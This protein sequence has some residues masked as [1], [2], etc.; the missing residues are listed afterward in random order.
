MKKFLTILLTVVLTAAVAITGTV[1]YLTAEDSDVNVMTLGNVKIDQLEYER[2]VD[3][4]GKFVST[5]TTDTYG[6]TPDKLQEFT[7]DKPLYPAVGEAKWD[8]NQQSWGQVGASGSN[9]L[10]DEEALKNVQDKFVFVK[11]T[12][13][14]EAY[15]RT[16]FA[17]EQGS[18][19]GGDFENVIA[20]SGNTNHWKWETVAT[21]VEIDGNKYVVA[22]ATYLGPKSNPTGILA[23][24]KVTYPSLLQVYMKPEATN[25]DCEAID[26]N[27]N[28][29]YDI[30]VFSQAVQTKGFD[31]AKTALDT[32]FTTNHPWGAYKE[33]TVYEAAT[34]EDLKAA[35]TSDDAKITVN[36]SADVTYDV[37]AWSTDAMGG[38]ATEEIVINGNGHT[39]TFNQTNSDWNNITT[40]GAKLVINDAKITNAGHNDGPWNRH[41]L[42]FA[43]DVE[44]N[45]V[46]SDKAIALKAN[47]TLN[48]VTI[49]DANTADT[50]A[51]WIQP[52]GQTVT[53]DGCT[54]D[55]LDCTDGRGIKIDNQY[56]PAADE[57]KVTLTVKDTTF[58]TEEKSAI[59]VKTT[60]GAKITVENIDITGVAADSTNAVWVDSDAAASADL[61]KVNGCSKIV[62]V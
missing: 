26:G 17:F 13:I 48:N 42:N 5:G 2:A 10:L 36:L 43:C 30:L 9:E 50:Y 11:N 33:A 25:E 38:A 58:K 56:V 19:A 32:A 39:I 54:I 18:V 60:V 21:D 35:L 6:Y 34:K 62:E 3:A 15:V 29:R 12:G 45:N 1:A 55:M 49:D 27:N 4:D 51:L 28:G 22:C 31:D 14:S 47:G 20:T 37:A 8:A 57:G 16:W 23:A 41:D 7:Q 44:L 40:N 53:L 59:L 46:T 61:V 24:G 52:N